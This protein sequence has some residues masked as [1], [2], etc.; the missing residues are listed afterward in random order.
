MRPH[1]APFIL[2]TSSARA[3][4]ASVPPAATPPPVGA[5]PLPI[6]K[7]KFKNQKF[8]IPLVAWLLGCSPSRILPTLTARLR[9]HKVGGMA[10]E[11]RGGA[12][13]KGQYAIVQD[14]P[15]YGWE[16]G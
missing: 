11:F 9:W 10:G 6:R 16:V 7:S 3:R 4:R 13:G 8:L 5:S 1:H 12:K 15:S 14:C 2:P